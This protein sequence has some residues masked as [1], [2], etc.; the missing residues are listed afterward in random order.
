MSSKTYKQI[1]FNILKTLE[2]GAS[3][4]GGDDNRRKLEQKLVKIGDEEPKKM[5][6]II[7]EGR[8][9]ANALAKKTLEDGFAP[10]LHTASLY[11][12][13]RMGRV[14]R[15]GNCDVH[16]ALA[17]T[18]ILATGRDCIHASVPFETMKDKNLGHIFAIVPAEGQTIKEGDEIKNLGKAVIIDSW[19]HMYLV[20]LQKQAKESKK[21][22]SRPAIC[23]YIDLYGVYPPAIYADLVSNEAIDRS[24]YFPTIKICRYYKSEIKKP[25]IE[26]ETATPL[27]VHIPATP[28]SV[29]I[30]GPRYRYNKKRYINK[31][32]GR[33]QLSR[34]GH[35]NDVEEFWC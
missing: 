21:K 10:D 11:A 26:P 15:M 16:S 9:E 14:C 31:N 8:D 35:M 12:Y 5:C 29:H 25:I 17:V 6:V 13:A 30:P 7:D 19:I 2:Y 4:I 23:D 28:L 22:M 18:G 3:N 27:S 32:P 1:V 20:S 33:S 24:Q 34:R